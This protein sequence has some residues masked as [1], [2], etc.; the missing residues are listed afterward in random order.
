M[1]RADRLAEAPTICIIFEAIGPYSGIG[2]AAM[3]G[4]RIALD[5]GWEVTVI[6]KRLD[7]QLQKE[8]EWL[9]LYVPPRLF[10]VQ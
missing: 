4:V 8:V 1:G 10:F 2:R 7:E 9:K 6:A 5:A 3:L